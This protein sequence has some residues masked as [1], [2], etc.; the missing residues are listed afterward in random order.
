MSSLLWSPSQSRIES[1]NVTHLMAAL[2]REYSVSFADYAAFHRWTLAEPEKFWLHL[3]DACGVRGES[4]DVVLEAGDKMPGAKWFPEA[5][6]NYA[7]NLLR[8]RKADAEMM[9]FTREDGRRD[10]W[11]YKRTIDAVSRMAAAL[12]A[13]GVGKGDR[14]AAYMPNCSETVIA[15]LAAVSLGATF[16]SA[17]PDFGVGG[18]VDRF[19]QIEP[20]VLFTVD[21]YVYGGK[22]FGVLDKAGEIAA[23]MPSLK[24]VIV[25]PFLT[26]ML[27]SLT[28]PKA[29]WWD[30]AIADFGPGKMTFEQVPFD[31]P[32]FILFSSGTTGVPKCIVH[33]H[34]GTLLQ[35]L[36]EH[37]YHGD[38]KP[39]DRVFYF[40]TCGWMMWNWLVTALA[41]EATI[42]LFDGSPGHP[43]NN[44]LFDFAAKERATFFGTSAKFIDAIKKAGLEP[45]KTHDLSAVR[46]VASTGSPLAPEAFDYVYQAIKADVHLASIA[47][48]TDIVG[49]F[50]CGMPTLPVHRGEIQVAALGMASRVYDADGNRLVGEKGELVCTQPFPS[51][52]VGFWNDPGDK[53]YKAAYFERFPNIWTH[54]DWAEET[55]NG[56]FVI[57]G[58][59][60][61]TLNPGGVRIGTAEIYR[62]VEAVDEVLEAIVVGQDWDNDVRVILFVVLKPGAVLDKA[63]SDKIRLRIRSNCTPRHVPAKIIAVA[64]IP[65]TKSG[66]IVELA[67]REVIH[68]RPVKNTD[69]LANPEALEHFRDLTELKS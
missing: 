69:A 43:D 8:P 62:Q 51:M 31:H 67:V 48:G 26:G 49:C 55:Q 54:G 20:K 19:G 66:K 61:A 39:G 29:V 18:A 52:P 63:L 45:A 24:Q 37:R 5:T 1:A 56:G 38:I 35:H 17:S 7:E 64:A 41:S 25:V 22:S 4:G 11:T 15:M 30:G 60:D 42:L 12:K 44:V 40:T 46:T 58:R 9:V 36:K 53:K 68:N 57:Y 2:A 27:S 32:L 14:V 28:L 65:R 13:I 10:V 34:G 59:S 3:W 33:G 16:S 50:V 21:G 23:R 47:G 6:L